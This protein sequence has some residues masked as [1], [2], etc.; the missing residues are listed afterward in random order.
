MI[1][2]YEEEVKWEGAGRQAVVPEDFAQNLGGDWGGTLGKKRHLT[3]YGGLGGT[4][5]SPPAASFPPPACPP[6]PASSPPLAL[7]LAAAGGRARARAADGAGGAGAEEGPDLEAEPAREFHYWNGRPV[8]RSVAR[9]PPAPGLG[10]PVTGGADSGDADWARHNWIAELQLA[11][12]TRPPTTASRGASAGGDRHWLLFGRAASGESGP[13][14]GATQTDF[15]ALDSR[16]GTRAGSRPGTS[17]SPPRAASPAAR[18]PADHSPL[19]RSVVVPPRPSAPAP[20][21][22]RAPAR[23]PCARPA[24]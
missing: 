14:A 11:P 3:R 24:R 22:A 8:T 13:G 10:R 12:A 1:D 4:S 19:S 5:P 9:A 20:A 16:P 6:P 21:V 7:S 23:P 17:H 2:T 18:S 15:L